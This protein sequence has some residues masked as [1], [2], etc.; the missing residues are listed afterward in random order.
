MSKLPHLVLG[1]LLA[2]TTAI[3]TAATPSSGKVS[4]DAPSVEWTGTLAQ[5]AAS[6]NAINN[7]NSAPC[8]PPSCDTFALE[9]ADGPAN[10]EL[11]INLGRTGSDGTDAD[12][13]FRI[14][15]PAGNVTF[16]SGPSNPE[17]AFKTVIKNAKSGAY[18]LDIVDSFVGAPGDYKAKATLLIPGA[19]A[20]A[21][22]PT[23]QP[24]Q[25]QQPG[26]AQPGSPGPT[27]TAKAGKA[28]ARKLAKARKLA[29]KLTTTAPLTKLAA[30]MRKGKKA[31]GKGSLAS[32]QSSGKITVKLPKKKLKPGSYKITVQGLDAQGRTVSAVASVKVA[33]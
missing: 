29:V 6:F 4:K 28:S 1:A 14:T 18:T 7:N 17:R 12:A 15:D 30:V 13:G 32:L 25:P 27:L 11:T 19:S 8:A 2:L 10:L 21:P 3:A 33:R 24:A 22:P 9:V 16:V 26:P 23:N 31:V 5:S 20:V